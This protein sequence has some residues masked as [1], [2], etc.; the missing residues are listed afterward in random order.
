M[1]FAAILILGFVL[2]LLSFLLGLVLVARF[3]TGETDAE[4]QLRFN[5]FAP[6]ML[7]GWFFDFFLQ[8]RDRPR[9]LT[10]RRDALGRFRK[11]PR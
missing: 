3:L 10:Y 4:R 11:L 2:V 7:T 8:W 5:P 6:A 9:Q 1:S